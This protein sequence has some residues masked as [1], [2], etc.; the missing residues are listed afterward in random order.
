MLSSPHHVIIG[1]QNISAQI[2]FWAAL[3]YSVIA[4]PTDLT[5]EASSA[6]FGCELPCTEVLLGVS[7]ATSGFVRLVSVERAQP[8]TG[9]FDRRPSAIDI[10]TTDQPRSV[11][12]AT[13]AGYPLDGQMDLPLGPGVTLKNREHLGPDG[14]RVTFVAIERRRPS[15]LDAQPELLHSEVHSLVT[16]VDDIDVAAAPFLAAGLVN[17]SSFGFESAALS[18]LMHL[19]RT[20][21]VKMNLIGDAELSPLR[22]EFLALD[23]QPGE[24]S[25]V[26]NWPLAAG[27]PIPGF[28]VQGANKFE[29]AIV[30]LTANGVEFGDVALTSGSAVVGVRSVRG[31]GPGN[32]T[33]ILSEVG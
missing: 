17:H 27:L 12:L 26:S 22:L 21:G 24:G 30:T 1:T 9:P 15:I 18:E 10:Y 31:Q 6:L 13:E 8:P 19:P 33:F 32:V 23:R 25:D 5:V 29:A 11:A 14:T 28:V 2:S 7:G 16:I 20:V 4:G 3:G